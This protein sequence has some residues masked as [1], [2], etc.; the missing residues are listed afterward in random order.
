MEYEEF[1]KLVEPIELV[2]DDEPLILMGTVDMI[3]HEGYAVVEATT[4]DQAF[5]FLCKHPSLQLLFTDVQMPGQLN[6]FDLAHVVAERW[7]SI[8]V[9][10]TSGGAQPG[11]GD[12]PENAT[13]IH[14]PFTP[15]LV[16]QV[17]RDHRVGL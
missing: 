16:H 6:G 10:V 3:A 7:P 14:K 17:L 2:V 5:R 11:P 4:A 9:I 8:R 12:M 13:F 1:A 15:E